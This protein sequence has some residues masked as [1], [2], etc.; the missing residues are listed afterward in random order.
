[1][2]TERLTLPE[3][4]HV[5]LMTDGFYRFVEPYRLETPQSLLARVLEHGLLLTLVA[6]RAHEAK[7]HG[8]R[9]KARDDAAAVLIRV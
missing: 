7:P 5:L 2:A 3:G 4:A 1:M 8:Q 6:L 9:L